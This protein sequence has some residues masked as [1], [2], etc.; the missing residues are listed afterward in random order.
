VAD[1]LDE[2]TLHYSTELATRIIEI[3]AMKLADP[4]TLS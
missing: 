4:S 2:D 1:A 3:A